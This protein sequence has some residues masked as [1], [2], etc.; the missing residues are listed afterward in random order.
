M[1]T[2]LLHLHGSLRYIVLLLLILAL[3]FAWKGKSGGH[4]YEGIYK[5][6]P[7]F[8][9]ILLHIQLVLGFAVYFMTG[10]HQMFGMIK[11]SD[12][13]FLVLEHPV[14]MLLGIILVTIGYSLAKRAGSAS[15]AFSRVISMYTL[16]LLVIFLSIPW[17]FLREGAKWF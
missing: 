17:P 5:R 12:I 7:M 3:V 1:E 14:G 4:A 6:M 15:K 8:A 10:K 16:G 9:M 2:G 11:Q 13:R